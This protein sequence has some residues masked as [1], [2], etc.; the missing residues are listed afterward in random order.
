MVGKRKNY[1]FNFFSF[2]LFLT[3]LSLI[4]NIIEIPLYPLEVQGD[5]KYRHF[6]KKYEDLF[7]KNA[8][9][10]Y[11]EIVDS[12]INREFVFQA[13]I[14]IGSR[15]QTF[16]LLID[17]GSPITWIGKIGCKGENNITRYFDPDKSI[18]N[19][20]LN[21]TFL[22]I[23][24][25][26]AT[27]GYYYLENVEYIPNSLITMKIGLADSAYYT[28]P[29]CDG[30]MGLSRIYNDERESIITMLYKRKYIDSRAFSI[31]YEGNFE[32]G[33]K[34]SMFL[35]I[36]DDFSKNETISAPLVDGLLSSTFNVNITSF[37]LKNNKYKIRSSEIPTPITI[38]TGSNV[39][40]LPMQYFEDIKN[41]LGK[42]D[43]QI[44]D[45]SHIK[46][47]RFKC[48]KNGNYP[49]FQFIING[50][51]FTIPKE[52][53]YFIKDNDKEHLYSK[54]IFINMPMYLIGSAFFHHFHILFDMDANDLKFYPINK[55]LMQKD[56]E[57][58]ESNA[59]SICLIII[60]SIALIAGVIFVVYFVF[61]KKK[62]KLDKNLTIESN[63]GLIKEEE[64]E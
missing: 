57:S 43:C 40:Y 7:P 53:A 44:E 38:D 41:N 10:S 58:N 36:H 13:Q 48:D 46:R 8:L 52:N 2:I 49:D 20:K 35:G 31:K 25:T 63:E 3:N 34:G 4:Y 9:L 62:K 64:R 19:I 37:G 61:I 17:T 23:Y 5:F 15:S 42:F 14:K 60:G 32:G 39:F 22:F 11:Y 47:M 12:E 50:Y 29:N 1:F 26:G 54:A 24:G 45:E 59:L 18:T 30:I 55:D 27:K 16:N 33:T 51:I 21:E 28:V 56:G 6:I